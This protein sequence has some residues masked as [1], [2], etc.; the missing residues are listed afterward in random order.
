MQVEWRPQARISLYTILDYISARNT[1]AAEDLYQ[2][3]ERATQSLPQHP[4]CIDT[5]ECSAPEKSW[6]TP[7]TSSF[8]AS[9]P[10]SNTPGSFS[11]NALS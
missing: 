7:I 3:I 8:T 10:A 2:T 6:F 4:T 9:M 5:E 1:V 11:R